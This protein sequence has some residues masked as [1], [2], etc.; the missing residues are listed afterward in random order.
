MQ[1]LTLWHTSIIKYLCGFTVSWYGIYTRDMNL[2]FAV[3]LRCII[4]IYLTWF[5][6]LPYY[7]VWKVANLTEF[8]QRFLLKAIK[9]LYQYVFSLSYVC[10]LHV[11]FFPWNPFVS[12]HACH[13]CLLPL[14]SL[15]KIQVRK[16]VTIKHL[17]AR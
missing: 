1:L 2:H 5:R 10:M 3:C 17:L 4:L 11:L 14:M 16:N 15:K 7:F 6:C 9:V 12:F 13:I 8:A